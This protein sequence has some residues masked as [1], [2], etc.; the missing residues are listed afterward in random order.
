MRVKVAKGISIGSWERQK[1]IAAL[2]CTYT[3]KEDCHGFQHEGYCRG[4]EPAISRLWGERCI[5]YAS[6]DRPIYILSGSEFITPQ[7]L[8][9][10]EK[11]HTVHNT[12][13]L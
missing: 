8:Q 4:L 7:A 3:H 2:I 5:H 9:Y 10:S 12:F 6:Q 11:K 1:K 13:F